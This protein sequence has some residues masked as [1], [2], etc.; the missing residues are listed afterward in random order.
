MG[1][2]R[3]FFVRVWGKLL[4]RQDVWI[5]SRYT[6]LK[7]LSDMGEEIS[8]IPEKTFLR[9]K[10]SDLLFKKS[11]PIIMN[12]RYIAFIDDNIEVSL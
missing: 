5:E 7:G 3:L 4:S 6:Y 9:V 2:F 8:D 10:W 11:L 1:I 12:V